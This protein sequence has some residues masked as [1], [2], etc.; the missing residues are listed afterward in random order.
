MWTHKTAIGA[1]ETTPLSPLGPL[2][3]GAYS[4]QFGSCGVFSQHRSDFRCTNPGLHPQCS[5]AWP[6]TMSSLV[7]NH[8]H[9]RRLLPSLE[10]TCGYSSSCGYRRRWRAGQW[11]DLLLSEATCQID[12]ADGTVAL[13]ASSPVWSC[14]WHP[15]ITKGWR[16]SL[17][18]VPPTFH[19]PKWSCLLS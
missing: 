4:L 9:L 15:F 10:S 7:L 1:D 8:F 6:K 12:K 16:A 2:E 19:L 3:A 14:C 5:K 17:I 13:S 18:F 11:S